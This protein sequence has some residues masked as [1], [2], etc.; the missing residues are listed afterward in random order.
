[1]A[2]KKDENQIEKVKMFFWTSIGA[3]LFTLSN[4]TLTLKSFI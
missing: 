4:V 3:W 1:M 2:K